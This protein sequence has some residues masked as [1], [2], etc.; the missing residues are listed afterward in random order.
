MQS[1][2]KDALDHLADTNAISWC[3]L[4][5]SIK[6]NLKEMEGLVTALEAASQIQREIEK[7]EAEEVI[8]MAQV[9][10]KAKGEKFVKSPPKA[11]I[12]QKPELKQIPQKNTKKSSKAPLEKK[13][14]EIPPSYTNA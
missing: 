6:F 3:P 12:K 13:K 9:I 8:K 11:E 4:K 5:T 2:F 7:R 1:D 10:E 14:P